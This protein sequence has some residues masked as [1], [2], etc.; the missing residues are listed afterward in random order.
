M[1]SFDLMAQSF[2]TEYR[3]SRARVVAEAIRDKIDLI[4]KR[5]VLEFGCGTGLVTVNLIRDIDKLTLV[6]SSEG[7]LRE[8]KTKLSKVC[9]DSMIHVHKDIFSHELIANSYDLLYSSMVLH[10]IH[11]IDSI[12]IRFNELLRD[13][14]TLCII[15]LLPVEKEYHSNET[16]FNGYHGFDPEWLTEQLSKQ[17]FAKESIDIIYTDS[18]LINNKKVDYSLFM[19]IMKNKASRNIH[20]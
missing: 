18:K 5:N 15:D 11:D 3:I 13:E 12:A 20:G 1:N 4:N 2:D 6:D 10:H 17:G 8:L 19:I 16:D 9:M 14:G 7:M